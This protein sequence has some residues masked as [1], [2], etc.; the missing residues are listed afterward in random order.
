MRVRAGEALG[1]GWKRAAGGVLGELQTRELLAGAGGGGSS[2][3]AAGWGGDRYELWRRGA[4][5]GRRDAALI[6]RW[7]WD[8]PADAREF[9]AKLRQW[10]GD[11]LG[12][13]AQDGGTFGIDG[14]HVA[15]ATRDGAV[16][17]AMAPSGPLARRLAAAG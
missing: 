2:A 16:T 15:V 11:G 10:V 9:E 4:G 7:R 6:V 3:A 1:D 5:E 8:T 14:G 13:T 12:A 17:L